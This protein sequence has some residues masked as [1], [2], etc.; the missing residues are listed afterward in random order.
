ML[1]LPPPGGKPVWNRS[2]YP[3]RKPDHMPAH[4]LPLRAAL[5]LATALLTAPAVAQVERDIN[6]TAEPTPYQLDEIIVTAT[7]RSENLQDV[8]GSVFALDAEGLAR[9]GIED[10]SRIEL[11]GAGITYGFIGNDAKIAIRGANSNNTFG[12]NSSIAGLFVDGV[13]KPRAS[14]QT[15]AFFDVERLEALKGPQGTLYGRNTFAGAINLVTRDPVLGATDGFA[16]AQYSS[17]N[18]FRVEAAT[19]L[20]VGDTLS[21]RIA[22]LLNQSG[23][24]GYIDNLAGP[25]QGIKDD[26]AVRATALW[27]PTPDFR[28]TLKLS[29]IE[30][31]GTSASV[32]AAVG[33]CRPVNADGLTDPLGGELD[34]G[35]PRRGAGGTVPF[36]PVGEQVDGAQGPYRV[37]QNYVPDMDLY[38][39]NATLTLDYD[40]GDFALTSI[41]SWTDYES[42]LGG[43]LDFSEAPFGRFF[44]EEEARSI[45]Q[46]LRI[47][48]DNSSALDFVAG[49]YFSDDDYQVEY[50]QY[51]SR[52]DDRDA[53]PLSPDG[54]T[55][56]TGTPLV[57]D[58]VVFGSPFI[59]PDIYDVQTYGVFGQADLSVTD[60]LRLVGGLRYNYESKA[61]ESGSNFD[62][63][64]GFVL[65]NEGTRTDVLPDD[66]RDVFAFLGQFGTVID[67]DFDRIT[68]RAGAEYD[69]GDT[70]LLYG[71]FSTGFLSGALS[72]NGAITEEQESEA[73]ELGLKTR[74]AGDRVQLNVAAYSNDYTNLITQEQ[75]TLASGLVVTNSVNG[76][77]IEARGLEVE[78]QALVTEALR[79]NANISLLDAEFGSFGTANPYQRLGG[80][81]V[82]FIALDGETP[83]WSPDFT[84]SVSAFYDIGTEYGTFTP[85]AQFYYSDSYSVSG[86]NLPFDPATRQESYTKTD[87]RLA[88]RAPSERYGVE[89][90]VENLEDEPVAARS[91]VGGEDILQGSYLFPRNFGVALKLNWD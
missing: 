65:A 72:G 83:P 40:L 91:T 1:R 34:C 79:V 88:W 8:G 90:F 32:F 22:G 46:E 85:S 58:E 66:P 75:T 15:R 69:L 9:A 6:E 63:S 77:D 71:S 18:R 64:F 70:T 47:S 89:V 52:V 50:S 3:F 29:S 12:D 80:E 43:D 61:L 73:F 68:W 5:L 25:E 11:I 20:P 45:T 17:F 59:R 41:S 36:S 51:S 13:Y 54:T 86:F 44:L 24:T 55:I 26:W 81:E 16:E 33:I 84:A 38:E 27:E 74:L 57:G 23:D 35:N 14:Q 19:S 60:R 53:R 49:L 10:I 78:A 48:S 39:R 82:A 28:A 2:D 67:E 56:L 21:F 76:G 37:S 62:G 30:D 42:L 7:K 31:N 87:L 4:R